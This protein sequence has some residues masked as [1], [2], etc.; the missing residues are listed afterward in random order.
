MQKLD[1]VGA[2]NTFVQKLENWTRKAEKGNFAMFE[3][4][5]TVGSDDV[6]DALSSEIL[7]HLTSL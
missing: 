4:L 2:L 5:S 7:I 6:D 1:F 3:A